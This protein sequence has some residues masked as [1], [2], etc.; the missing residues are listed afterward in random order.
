MDNNEKDITIDDIFKIAE[1]MIKKM[2]EYGS[3]KGLEEKVAKAMVNATD[4]DSKFKADI[5]IQLSS[6][7]SM[8]EMLLTYVNK[9]IKAEGILQRKMDGSILLNNS[10]VVPNGSLVEYWKDDKWN[11]G[12]LI[13]DPTT[14]QSKIVIV[15]NNKVAIDKIE[16]VK[17]RI[18]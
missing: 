5:A 11:L 15:A 18:R 1:A 3:Q 16:Q 7:I 10:I 12:K 14:K 17:S 4:P 9:P 13:Q 2:H 8:M 6:I